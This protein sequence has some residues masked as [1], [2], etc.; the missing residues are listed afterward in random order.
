MARERAAKEEMEVNNSGNEDDAVWKDENVVDD[1]TRLLETNLSES[2]IWQQLSF[3]ASEHSLLMQRSVAHTYVA[4]GRRCSPFA[5]SQQADQRC[6]Q[7]SRRPL[8]TALDRAR[9]RT[10]RWLWVQGI[11]TSR[12][13]KKERIFGSRR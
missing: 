13:A 5:L 10:R 3:P 12:K 9:Y 1:E 11:C 2:H 4:V 6:V 8:T 7:M